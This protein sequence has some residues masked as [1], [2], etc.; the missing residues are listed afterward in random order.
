M[1]DRFGRGEAGG[2]WR[3][4]GAPPDKGT[5]LN[6]ARS[7]AAEASENANQATIGAVES[8]TALLS[9]NNE[10]LERAATVAV[11]ATTGL[12]LAIKMAFDAAD[13]IEELLSSDD[14]EDWLELMTDSTPRGMPGLKSFTPPTRGGSEYSPPSFTHTPQQFWTDSALLGAGPILNTTTTDETPDTDVSH[15]GTNAADQPSIGLP[16]GSEGTSPNRQ[17]HPEDTLSNKPGD[18]NPLWQADPS[19]GT[20]FVQDRDHNDPVATQ[21]ESL[22]SRTEHGL[23]EMD[24]VKKE[25]NK[26]STPQD[27]PRKF[28]RGSKNRAQEIRACQHVTRSR[29]PRK[30]KCTYEHFWPP[31]TQTKTGQFK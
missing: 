12:E 25:V 11:A 14:E 9:A 6:S 13:T 22:R 19:P 4:G 20:G 29:C 10:T 23:R 17:K 21:G 5:L 8:V 27:K 3:D 31:N 2:V 15:G 28:G 26:D 30:D 1:D 18:L 24:R 16:G 7:S